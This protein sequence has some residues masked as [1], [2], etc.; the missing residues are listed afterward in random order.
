M[1]ERLGNRLQSGTMRVQIPPWPPN[2]IFER[3]CKMGMFNSIYA[4][5]LCPVENRISKNT[6]IQ[7]K[8]QIKKARLLNHYRQGDYLEDLEDEFNNNWIRTEYICEACSKHSLYKEW[9]FIKVE[10]QKWHF[11]FVNIRQGRIEQILTVEE[12]Q[13]TDVK[14]FVIYD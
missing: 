3:G 1:A 14:D 11:V 6:E 5:I 8:W 10:D 7:I 9:P 13:K 12:F 2:F 4:D